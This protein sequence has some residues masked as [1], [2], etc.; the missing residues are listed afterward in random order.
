[1]SP[2]SVL[3]SVTL[4][5]SAS[6]K[7]TQLAA[8]TL[9]H[10]ICTFNYEF[11]HSLT[12]ACCTHYVISLMNNAG[13]ASDDNN[14]DYEGGSPSPKQKLPPTP[15]ASTSAS[16]AAPPSALRSGRITLLCQTVACLLTQQYHRMTCWPQYCSE[17]MPLC[18][19][20]IGHH[21]SAEHWLSVSKLYRLQHQSCSVSVHEC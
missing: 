9:F 15:V 19:V 1:M 17:Q 8:L 21:V 18:V 11:G 20:I 2:F 10:Y 7:S 3:C 14:S 6:N 5:A 12:T 4:F 13:D 16:S